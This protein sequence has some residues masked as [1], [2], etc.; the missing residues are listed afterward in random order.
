[1]AQPEAPDGYH[2]RM[3]P[4]KMTADGS[5]SGWTD[6]RELNASASEGNVQQGHRHPYIWFSRRRRH[7]D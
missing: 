2:Y 1:M 4:P 7:R 6:H 3:Q 5:N